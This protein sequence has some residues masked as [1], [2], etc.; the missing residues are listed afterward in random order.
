MKRIMT[1]LA[2]LGLAASAW[3]APQAVVDAVQSPAWRDRE[4]RAEALAPGMELQSRD[5]IRT[6]EGSR[7]YLKLADGS[8][9][10]LGENGVLLAERLGPS[11]SQFFSAA[12]DV[13]RGAFRFTTNKL[14]KLSQRDIT[15]RYEILLRNLSGKTEAAALAVRLK[16][17]TGLEGRPSL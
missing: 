7:V 16:A 12:L 1:T 14:R 10:K 17:Q 11:E 3:A 13:A 6:G 2:L 4:G 5:R 9:V 15:I 8:T